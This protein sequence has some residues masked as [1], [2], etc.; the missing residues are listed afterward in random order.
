MERRYGA[1]GVLTFFLL[2]ISSTAWAEIMVPITGTAN[3][4]ANGNEFSF[5]GPGVAFFSAQPGGPTSPNFCLP[6]EAGGSCGLIVGGPSGLYAGN[7]SGLLNGTTADYVTSPLVFS[8]GPGFPALGPI[9]ATED[10][11]VGPVIF[12]GTL[13]GYDVNYNSPSSVELG[14]LQ[15]SAYVS[16][17]G[18]LTISGITEPDPDDP[19]LQFLTPLDFSYQFSGVLVVTPEPSRL[20]LA[21]ICLGIAGLWALRRRSVAHLGS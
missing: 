14:P 3:V 15:F 16:G 5:S 11:I 7:S 17:A 1:I 13:V 12:S 6:D 8:L 18:T 4:D 20:L 9:P 2:A 10:E 19:S 21:S